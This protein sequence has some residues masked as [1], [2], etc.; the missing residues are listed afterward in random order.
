[1]PLISS[2]VNTGPVNQHT[3]PRRVT[4]QAR[5]VRPEHLESTMPKLDQ[6]EDPRG[7]AVAWALLNVPSH[8]SDHERRFRD[9]CQIGH[10]VGGGPGGPRKSGPRT[11]HGRGTQKASQ[12]SQNGIEPAIAGFFARQNARHAPGGSMIVRG[13]ARRRSARSLETGP[14][15]AA[16]D[17]TGFRT[18]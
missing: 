10:P 8:L 11:G 14:G 2:G 15:A 4:P 3:E 18:S 9:L 16:P 13:R 12:P 17:E 5:L 6:T 1:M 7:G